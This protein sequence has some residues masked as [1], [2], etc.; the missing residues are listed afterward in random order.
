MEVT[1]LGVCPWRECWAPSWFPSF[2]AFCLTWGDGASSAMMIILVQSSKTKKS[3][4]VTSKT[5]N[6]SKPFFLLRWL[7]QVFCL[8]SR[9][10]RQVLRCLHRMKEGAQSRRVAGCTSNLVLFVFSTLFHLF[11]GYGKLA[12][13][14]L[15]WEFPSPFFISL[16]NH[17][18]Y[19]KTAQESYSYSCRRTN[20][21]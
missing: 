7:P 6:Q 14:F 19:W 21:W 12:E 10:Q 11:P 9:Q 20:S 13:Q 15:L 3:W 5:V 18:M 17:L 16:F 1:S 8:S 4:T 2:C